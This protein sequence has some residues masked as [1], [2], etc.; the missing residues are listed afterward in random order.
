VASRNDFGSA[1]PL[2]SQVSLALAEA[3]A[4]LRHSCTETM[5]SSRCEGVVLDASHSECVA[6][7]APVQSYVSEGST[8]F[9]QARSE[10]ATARPLPVL[11]D[12][13][14]VNYLTSRSLRVGIR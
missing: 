14:N 3:D 1:V 10:G 11:L 12:K 9:M 5:S 4:A 13:A 2:V 7:M 6:M 8:H